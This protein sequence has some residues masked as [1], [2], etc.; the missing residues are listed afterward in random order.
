MVKHGVGTIGCL[1]ALF[2]GAPPAISAE[3][4]Q[5]VE[6]LCLKTPSASLEG[7]AIACYSERACSYVDAQKGDP[8]RD[9]DTESVAAALGREKIEGIVTSSIQIM[10]QISGYGYACT[11]LP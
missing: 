5:A 9:Y 1:L 7:L 8:L 10:K 6:F 3:N 4:A 2:L 11:P